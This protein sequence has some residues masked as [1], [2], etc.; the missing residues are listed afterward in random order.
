MSENTFQL[1]D[2]ISDEMIEELESKEEQWR[3]QIET[4]LW[5]GAYEIHHY[6]AWWPHLHL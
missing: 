5:K 1:P 4:Y 2:D 6:I 3:K